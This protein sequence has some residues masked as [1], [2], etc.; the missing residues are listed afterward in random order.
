MR[1]IFKLLGG[2]V[3]GL[4]A[5]AAWAGIDLSHSVT[6][7]VGDGSA[8][9]PYRLFE[10]TGAAAGEKLPLVLFLHGMGERGTDNVKQTT[11]MSGLVKATSKGQYASYVLAPQIDTHSWFSSNSGK[12]TEAMSLTIEAV[13]DVIKTQNIDPSRVYVTGLSMGGMGTWD[14]LEREPGLF[15]AAVPMSGSGDT[16][17]AG[18][19]KD[20]AIWAFHGSADPIVSVDGTRGMIDAL[21]DAGGSPRYTEIAGAGH[22]IWD[23]VYGDSTHTLYPWLFAQSKDGAVSEVAAEGAAVVP[24]AVVP[25]PGTL[26]LL[27]IGAAALAGRRRPRR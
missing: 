2:A 26:G 15:A 23:G 4:C 3:V 11:W 22:E 1:R 17:S 8:T 24:M 10:P 20:T 5:N 25:E 21:R 9:L 16:R 13:K 6:G 14:I 12:P 7:S 18:V 27:V 19:I